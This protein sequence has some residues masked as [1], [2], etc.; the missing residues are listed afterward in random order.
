MKGVLLRCIL[1]LYMFL[2]TFLADNEVQHGVLF[3]LFSLLSFMLVYFAVNQKISWFFLFFGIFFFLGCWQKVVIHH[4]FGYEYVEPVGDFDNAYDQWS[5]YYVSASSMALGLILARL[6]ALVLGGLAGSLG[7]WR[8]NYKPVTNIEWWGLVL[9]SAIFYYFNNKFAFF[10]TGVNP[11]IVLPLSFNAPVSFIALIGVP[12]VVS[13]YVS[14]DLL[15][16]R[17]LRFRALL[18]LLLISTMASV[19]MASRAAVVMQVIP[20]LVASSYVL[21]TRFGKRLNIYPF[22]MLFGFLIFSIFLVSVYRI[23]VFIGAG[24]D[25]NEYMYHY[26]FESLKLVVDRWIGAEAIMV[27][28]AE[29]AGSVE[30]LFD[31]IRE[32]PRLGADAIYQVLSGGKY[33][34]VDGFTFLTLPGYFGVLGLSGAPLLMFFGVFFIVIFG[35]IFEIFLWYA[36]RGQ[37]VVV[38][39]ISAFVANSITQ[40]SFPVLLVPSLIQLIFMVIALSLL[41]AGWCRVVRV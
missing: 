5:A 12:V 31:L 19:S 2:M 18:V 3:W 21:V 1:F 36:L 25:F 17:S 4:I 20:I 39:L 10:V 33:Q 34:F 13:L 16:V 30:L 35:L 24:V 32:S 23:N 40:L 14:R 26:L 11:K 8:V 9:L 29:S 22:L 28:V 41:T 15:S 27:S 6:F 7:E 37:A 38:A